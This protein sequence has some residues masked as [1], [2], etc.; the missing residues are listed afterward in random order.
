M[1]ERARR[2]LAAVE[3]EED[4]IAVGATD[5]RV[6][7]GVL[8]RIRFLNKIAALHALGKHLGL[9]AEKIDQS[10]GGYTFNI[11]LIE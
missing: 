9:F 6:C 5:N 11:H 4:V 7:T 2:S 8:R 1:P 10:L 3:V